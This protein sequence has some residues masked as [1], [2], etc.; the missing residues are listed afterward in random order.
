[1]MDINTALTR[2]A[3]LEANPRFRLPTE[4]SRDV[5]VTLAAEIRRLTAPPAPVRDPAELEGLTPDQV[6]FIAD[7]RDG[8]A[9]MIRYLRERTPVRIMRNRELPDAPPWALVIADNAEF[10]LGCYTTPLAASAE[11]GRLELPVVAS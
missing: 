6:S 5:I 8:R 2:A 4:V 11:A 3:T 10:W 1:M 9:A 7:V